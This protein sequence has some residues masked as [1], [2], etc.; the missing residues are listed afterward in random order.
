MRLSRAFGEG[1]VVM[2]VSHED[3]WN[4]SKSLSLCS[5]LGM[6][7]G[8]K[9]KLDQASMMCH[10]PLYN[11]CCHLPVGQYVCHGKMTSCVYQKHLGQ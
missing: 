9:R 7:C 6:G 5:T 1:R 8:E 2:A 3:L 11:H 10:C 4:M